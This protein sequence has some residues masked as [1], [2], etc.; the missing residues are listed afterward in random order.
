MPIQQYPD[1]ELGPRH[2][3]AAETLHPGLVFYRLFD[4]CH[5]VPLRQRLWD[6]LAVT[7]TGRFA[8]E[9]YDEEFRQQVVDMYAQVQRLLEA[10]HVLYLQQKES[11]RRLDAAERAMTNEQ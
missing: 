8:S 11:L 5:L 1:Y 6:W 3:D 4:Y 7:V 10:A 2:L 9:E